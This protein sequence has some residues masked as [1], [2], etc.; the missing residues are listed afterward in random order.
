MYA[1]VQVLFQINELRAQLGVKS[2]EEEA[3]EAAAQVG[4]QS[5]RQRDMGADEQF[6]SQQLVVQQQQ[7]LTLTAGM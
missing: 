5:K 3:A 6:S 4:R 2:L 1:P 7:Q